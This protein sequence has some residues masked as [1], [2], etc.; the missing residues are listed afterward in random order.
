MLHVQYRLPLSHLE[1]KQ[2]EI[3]KHFDFTQ[4][5][6]TKEEFEKLVKLISEF[7]DVYTKS[8]YDFRLNKTSFHILS[9]IDA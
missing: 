9:K 5:D 4:R 2:R 7:K 8:N 3:L 6:L 1:Q